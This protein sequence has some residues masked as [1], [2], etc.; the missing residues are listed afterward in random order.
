LPLRSGMTRP[1]SA[2]PPWACCP[3]VAAAAYCSS[4]TSDLEKIICK[5][6][7]YVFREYII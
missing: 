2:W 3:Y 6:N 7:L 4:W 5:T 1:S